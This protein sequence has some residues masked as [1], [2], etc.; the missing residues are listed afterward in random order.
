MID[1]RKDADD[2]LITISQASEYLHVSNTTI[3]NWYD[4]G[5]LKGVHGPSGH[6]KVWKSSLDAMK[7]N[8]TN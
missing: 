8:K 1:H 7:Y 6:R 2:I 5:K 3:R 4:E